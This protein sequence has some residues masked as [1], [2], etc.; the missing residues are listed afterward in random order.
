[1]TQEDKELSEGELKLKEE[2]EQKTREAIE[3]AQL[4]EDMEKV[5]LPLE[6]V[7]RVDI[8][9]DGTM[10]VSVASIDVLWKIPNKFRDRTV[11]F[12]IG[13]TGRALL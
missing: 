12:Q 7:L 1:M 2:K 4:K 6:G 8:G 5:Y 11:K 13:G 3:R 9:T 10:N